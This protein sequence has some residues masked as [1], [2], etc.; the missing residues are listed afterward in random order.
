MFAS[1]LG[2]VWRQNLSYLKST[3]RERPPDFFTE[4]PYPLWEANVLNNLGLICFRAVKKLLLPNG[5]D[6]GYY[7]KATELGASPDFFR[8]FAPCLKY[9]LEI[10][11]VGG[12]NTFLSLSPCEICCA[13]Y[14]I[15]SLCNLRP[16]LTLT[17]IN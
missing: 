5:G 2:V 9:C 3:T 15:A 14:Y 1:N 6:V 13:I 8:I 10:V 11:F 7:F 4:Y 16:P 17:F 12:R